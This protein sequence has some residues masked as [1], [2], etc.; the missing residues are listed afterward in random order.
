MKK[1][2]IS[3]ANRL[4]GRLGGYMGRANDG[5]PGPESLAIGLR[6]LADMVTGWKLKR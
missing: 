1:L 5:E 6:R 2:T 3:E 4:V